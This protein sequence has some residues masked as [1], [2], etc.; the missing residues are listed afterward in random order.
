MVADLHDREHRGRPLLSYASACAALAGKTA[1][2]TRASEEL[3][4]A[5][6]CGRI[7]AEPVC[8]DRD[9]PPVPRSAMDGYAVSSSEGSDPRQIAG[10]IHAGTPAAGALGKGQAVAV[11]TGG[12]VPPGADCVIPVEQVSVEGGLLHL[13]EAPTAGR[14]VRPAGE[15]GR[16]GRTVLEAGMRLGPGELMIAA[17]CGAEPVRVRPRVRVAVVSTGDEVVPWR[18]PPEAHQVRD[19]NRLGVAAR[20]TALGAEIVHQSHLRDEPQALHAGLQEALARADL[21]ITIG[22]VSMGEKDYLPASFAALGVQQRLHGVA[23]QPG[24][25]VW[26]GRSDSAWVI[27]L[28]GNPL[29]SFVVTELFARPMHARLSGAAGESWPHPLLPG[30]AATSASS[31]GRELW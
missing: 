16:A 22:G 9:E 1:A 27:G 13:A 24:K 15:I 5:R 12:T 26:I 7:L 4:L 6:A 18:T 29:S 2:L 17:S 3:Q 8:L 11:M 30:V 28:P 21:L 10:V 14:H 31:R 19:A 20:L 25:P 23:L